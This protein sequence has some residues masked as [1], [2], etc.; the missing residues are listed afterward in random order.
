MHIPRTLIG[1]LLLTL[2]ASI[3]AADFTWTTGAGGNNDALW[4]RA[5]NWGGAGTPNAAG[6]TAN[7]LANWPTTAFGTRSIQLRQ[8]P[9]TVGTLNVNTTEGNAVLT[10]QT[11]QEL[12]FDNNGGT[13]AFNGAGP[14]GS[15]SPP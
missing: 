15:K 14:M 3:H 13:A 2:G 5:P 7:I 1:G 6:D 11:T 8:I 10:L 12:V 4:D 9:T